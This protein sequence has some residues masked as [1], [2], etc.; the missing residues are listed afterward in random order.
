[1][2]LAKDLAV[3]AALRRKAAAYDT[4]P[5]VHRVGGGR[6]SASSWG[7]L[8]EDAQLRLAQQGSAI[9]YA[10]LRIIAVAAGTP[11]W[12]AE[13]RRGDGWTVVDS[14]D[15][16]GA[17]IDQPNGFDDWRSLMERLTFCL[18]PT[19]NHLWH[20]AP[21]VGKGGALPPISGLWP[22]L[23]GYLPELG[24]DDYPI[25]Y[26]RQARGS[27][28][29]KPDEVIHFQRVNARSLGWGSGVG[30]A[31][32]RVVAA[33][34]AAAEHQQQSFDN[35]LVPDGV[36]VAPPGI[37]LTDAERASVKE[38][39]EGR[40]GPPTASKPLMLEGG[41]KFERF[42]STAVEADFVG[43]RRAILEEICA[44]V[45]LRPAFLVPDAS[46][47]N[48]EQSRK[49]LWLDNVLPMLAALSGK[50]TRHMAP[51]F[52]KPGEVR[53]RP[54]TETVE[55]LRE[56][57]QERMLGFQ[58]AV[59]N[60]IP[61]D[62]AINL[63]ALPLRPLGAGV[64]NIP[65]GA[66]EAIMQDRIRRDEGL[67]ATGSAGGAGSAS[68][69]LVVRAKRIAAIR[70]ERLALPVPRKA[71]ARAQSAD[72]FAA[73]VDLERRL[74]AAY[75]VI[76]KVLASPSD[77]RRAQI[78]AA[79][80][81]G[82]AAAVARA[83]GIDILR[84]GLGLDPAGVGIDFGAGFRNLMDLILDGAREGVRLGAQ[85]LSD[86]AGVA[87]SVSPAVAAPW[88]KV[89]APERAQEE[90]AS[91]E[92]GIT[93]AVAGL[94]ALPSW[95]AAMAAAVAGLFGSLAAVHGQQAQSV[96]KLVESLLGAER[97]LEEAVRRA[98]RMALKAAAERASL[99]AQ[100]NATRATFGGQQ[101]AAQ[102][103]YRGGEITSG[104][105]LWVDSDDDRVCPICAGLDG[106]E[107]DLDGPYHSPVNGVE[108]MTPGDPHNRCRC[109]E[110]YFEIEAAEAA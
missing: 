50:I 88:V 90:V 108:Y 32:A 24:D 93:E 109:G 60:G 76:A 20:K 95:G 61:Y 89:W 65:F 83:A 72:L 105:R 38:S 19:G 10:A 40:I 29:Y 73:S 46:Y 62:D 13:R 12:V 104:R 18:I 26:K 1:M 11:T 86:A 71:D 56:L 78:V 4:A 94:R 101:L 39:I 110:I 63:F 69:R 42:T 48:L 103:L 99:I 53:W 7:Q 2:S 59:R 31:A 44:V 8:T 37:A 15:P 14:G 97:G 16:A 43:T 67:I 80:M 25:H 35:R 85:A 66:S 68:E 74:A 6:R 3:A 79:L 23:P 57:M 82:D 81:G 27:R 84:Q 45:N 100:H 22:L 47:A 70:T 55:A 36:F 92:R 52:G 49:S 51:H 34:I 9:L 87:L 17:I 41:W 91:T 98:E 30:A 58:R 28:E 21:G 64:G 33:D 75:R 102:E 106:E 77:D 96:R 54:D 5:V 107:A